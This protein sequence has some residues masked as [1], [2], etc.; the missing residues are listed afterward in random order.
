[1]NRPFCLTLL[2]LSLFTAC[3]PPD[4][5]GTY[6][7]EGE[8]V[9][10]ITLD[11]QTRDQRYPV[12]PRAT[13][14]NATFVADYLITV[15]GCGVDLKQMKEGHASVV[16]GATCFYPLD[17]F[18]MAEIYRSGTLSEIGEEKMDYFATGD[19]AV[20]LSDGSLRT[21]GT[22]RVSA[23]MEKTS[24]WVG[25]SR[26]PEDANATSTSRSLEQEGNR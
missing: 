8:S 7:S 9:W 14:S 23:S 17:G 10:R 5:T 11:G 26:E 16:S 13:V 20:E 3:G 19:L 4:Y 2:S 25:S 15:D 21:I 1:M 18:R 6:S 12:A 22:F 24:E